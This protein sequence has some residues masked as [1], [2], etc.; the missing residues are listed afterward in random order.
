MSV[1]EAKASI[2]TLTTI[3]VGCLTMAIT[4]YV[5]LM[6]ITP[7]VVLG[8]VFGCIGL[9]FLLLHMGLASD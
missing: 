3:T 4:R 6:R 8:M 5:S 7:A 9:F 1:G 2:F